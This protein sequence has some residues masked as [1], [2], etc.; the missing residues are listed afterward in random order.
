MNYFFLSHGANEAFF[1][2]IT[3]LAKKKALGKH[4]WGQA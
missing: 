3:S 4:S 2:S 1:D